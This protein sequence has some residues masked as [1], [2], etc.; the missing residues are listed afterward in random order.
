M[1]ATTMHANVLMGCGRPPRADCERKRARRAA[2]RLRTR[3]AVAVLGLAAL[4]AGAYGER[5]VLRDAPLPA[6]EYMVATCAALTVQ[7]AQAPNVCNDN[8]NESER[9]N[10]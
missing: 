5:W 10:P 1:T 6:L 8:G 7:N 3:V 9:N 4:A 2:R